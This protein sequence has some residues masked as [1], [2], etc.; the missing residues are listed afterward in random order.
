VGAEDRHRLD[1]YFESIRQLEQQ[2]ALQL[3]PPAPVENF[4][5]PEEPANV[6]VNS[7]VENVMANHKIM[8]GLLAKA[9]QS[10]QT[11]VFNMLLSDT[12]SNLHHSGSTTTHHTMTHEEHDDPV[13]GYQKEHAW[14]ATRSMIAWR[15]F[16]DELASI[17]EGDGTLLDNTLILAHSDC[18]IAKSHAV[19][20]IPVMIAGSGGGRVRTGF[21]MAGK[22]DSLARIG[23]TVQQAMGVKV[24]RWGVK[25]METNRVITDLLA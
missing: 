16:L 14:F 2:I 9:L 25:S 20:G 4:V 1:E 10:N 19:E 8:A 18:S 21:H 22:G 17:P 24:D 3:Q 11:R 6:T 7:E 15:E 5:M 12:A 13:L 23:L